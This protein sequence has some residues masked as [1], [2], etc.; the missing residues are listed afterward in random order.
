MYYLSQL[1]NKPAVFEG[2]NLG[3]VSDLVVSDN[4]QV[5]IVS[6]IVLR[7]GK[8]K[9]TISSDAISLENGKW[10]LK[11]RDIE[12][13]P[14][15]ENDFY[16]KEDL[17]D[18]QVIDL[19]GRRLVRVNDVLFTNN[20][21]IKVEGIDIGASGII[22]RLGF[23]FLTTILNMKTITLPWSLIEAFDYQTGNVQ[24]KLTQSKLNTFHPAEVADILEEAGTKERL[25]LVKAL[26]VQNA[27]SA[28]SEADTETQSA[29]LEQVSSNRLKTIVEKMRPSELADVLDRLNPFTSNQILTNLSDEKAKRVKKLLVF[30]DDEAGGLMDFSFYKQYA[31][32]TV[33]ETLDDIAANQIHPEAVI[34]VDKENKFVGIIPIKKI[35]GTS[36]SVELQEL[37]NN[38]SFVY[39]DASFSQILKIFA[40]YNLRLLP[41]LDKKKEVAGVIMIDSIL[42][43]IQEEEEKEDAL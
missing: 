35:V 37:I 4:K 33:K 31:D 23:R 12:H 38:R 29:I 10:V 39:E 9:F 36:H 20:G 24:L 11:T 7:H 43:R 17:L 3:K 21:H 18:K 1:L 34:V 13:L 19:N 6:K 25:G 32:K 42:E 40:E 30:E 15:D 5:P 8:R 2:Q 28:I 27:A 16:L 41:V 22:R 26:D 14:F